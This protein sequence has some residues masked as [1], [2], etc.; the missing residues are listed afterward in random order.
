M[1]RFS[2]WS[3]R[4]M[5]MHIAALML[6]HAEPGRA[7]GSV[8][9]SAAVDRLVAVVRHRVAQVPQ[10]RRRLR[11]PGVPWAACEWVQDPLFD[12]A[13]HVT[14]SVIDVPS[15]HCMLA[16][17]AAR[18]LARPL[19]RA[20]PLW[21]I[22]ILGGLRGGELALL[23]K[24]HHALADGLHALTLAAS[25]FDELD[26][27][28]AT[29]RA[30]GTAPALDNFGGLARAGARLNTLARTALAD[31]AGP[32]RWLA[33]QAHGGL[34]R[35]G[36]LHSAARIAAAV[37]RAAVRASSS[38]PFN[39]TLV[40]TRRLGMLTLPLDEIHRVG[41]AHGGTVNDVLLAVAAGALRSWLAQHGHPR[42]PLRAL[43]PVSQ[44]RPG[45]AT[46]NAISGYLV[47][48]PVDVPDPGA[49]LR[50]IHDAM[51]ANKAAGPTRGAGALPL[52]AE[53]LPPAVV[54]LGLPPAAPLLG[55]LAPRLFNLVITNVAFPDLPLHIDGIR[56]H[57][58]YPYLPLGPRQGLGLA[59]GTYQGSAHLGIQ[60]DD[61]ATGPDPDALAACLRAALDE[62]AS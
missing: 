61:D 48:L 22:R 3:D 5:P 2:R 17:E 56:L 45:A 59:I 39:A 52:L 30:S 8:P 27:A 47:T 46:G 23:A 43:V 37:T 7:P 55:H 13:I 35:A 20:R 10:L 14:G 19:D 6:L 1:R 50:L 11:T 4:A 15:G 34:S 28:P 12:P 33:G 9:P 51:T 31:P 21:E 32:A 40:P 41:K 62:L 24:V 53:A 54:R 25:L 57:E 42:Y 18:H 49:R 60:T 58:I 38:P 29:Q 16:A 44:C 26:Q 36:Q